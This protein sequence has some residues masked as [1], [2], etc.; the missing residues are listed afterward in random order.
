ML[1]NEI[2]PASPSVLIALINELLNESNVTADIRV[3]ASIYMESG[4]AGVVLDFFLSQPEKS[5]AQPI[6]RVSQFFSQRLGFV[7]EFAFMVITRNFSSSSLISA[8]SAGK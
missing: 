2:A 1:Q 3:P 4:T 8:A 7:V 6:D 5:R